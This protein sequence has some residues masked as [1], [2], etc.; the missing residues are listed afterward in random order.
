MI[1][2]LPLLLL[3]FNYLVTLSLSTSAFAQEEKSGDVIKKG[4]EFFKNKTKIRDPFNLRDPFK[5]PILSKEDKVVE[6]QE[7]II[8]DGVFTNLPTIE[9]VQL[10]N[11][12]ITGILMGKERRALATISGGK[13]GDDSSVVIL[14]EGMTLGEDKAEIKAILPGGVVLVEKITNVYGQEEY[15]ETILPII[16]GKLEINKS[17]NNLK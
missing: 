17:V 14:K 2:S 13:S 15:L 4:E 10:D 7:G 11:I 12:R 16:E 1:K 9:N 6:M 5:K 3:L 8:K